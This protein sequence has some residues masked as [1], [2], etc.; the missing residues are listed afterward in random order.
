MLWI[1]QRQAPFAINFQQQQ[2]ATCTLRRHSPDSGF[3]LVADVVQI[4]GC[5]RGSVKMRSAACGSRAE[6]GE[7]RD[8]ERQGKKGVSPDAPIALKE[9]KGKKGME[10]NLQCRGRVKYPWQGRIEEPICRRESFVKGLGSRQG[11]TGID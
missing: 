9:R 8:R 5:M 10:Y 6:S 2:S 1:G 3:L 11:F 4:S 7:R